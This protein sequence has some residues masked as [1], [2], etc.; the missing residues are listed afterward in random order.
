[1]KNSPNQSSPMRSPENFDKSDGLSPGYDPYLSLMDEVPGGV[2]NFDIEPPLGQSDPA[3]PITCVEIDQEPD[4]VFATPEQSSPLRRRNY[5]IGRNPSRSSSRQTSPSPTQRSPTP[6]SPIKFSE[7]KDLGDT[8]TKISR[9]DFDSFSPIKDAESQNPTGPVEGAPPLPMINIMSQIDT[10]EYPNE[11][12]LVVAGEFHHYSIGSKDSIG[13]EIEVN[14]KELAR[15]RQQAEVFENK[16]SNLK[17]L[18]KTDKKK[19][20]ANKFGSNNDKNSGHHSDIG[21][22]NLEFQS[23]DSKNL[24]SL[25]GL[26]R[27]LAG[28]DADFIIDLGLDGDSNLQGSAGRDLDIMIA[29]PA[30]PGL[31]QG[32]SSQMGSPSFNKGQKDSSRI[33]SDRLLKFDEQIREAA[34]RAEKSQRNLEIRLRDESADSDG[35][36]QNIEVQDFEKDDVLPDQDDDDLNAS[37]SN[38]RK[39]LNMFGARAQYSPGSSESKEDF[40]DIDLQNGNSAEKKYA[41]V[42]KQ[43]NE[44]KTFMQSVSGM[45]S[46]IETNQK[47]LQ[48]IFLEKNPNQVQEDASSGSTL[49][50]LLTTEMNESKVQEFMASAKNKLGV[51]DSGVKK[52]LDYQ[53]LGLDGSENDP[54]T[55]PTKDFVFESPKPDGGSFGDFDSTPPTNLRISNEEQMPVKLYN[56]PMLGFGNKSDRT[57]TDQD[58]KMAF[59][60]FS[61]M[62][63][64]QGLNSSKE[65]LKAQMMQ[66][67]LGEFERSETL[68]Q[69]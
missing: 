53:A 41:S 8:K 23:N 46:K 13:R 52:M 30:S 32:Q 6:E 45:V 3:K 28:E 39:G 22:K 1:V 38:L 21:K 29:P 25:S 19:T 49:E 33:S 51:L 67:I 60:S 54:K 36:D 50:N 40:C 17:G 58:N 5:S 16:I 37:D 43:L 63:K 24:E 9:N 69:S 47:A 34:I 14:E 15:L 42:K 57:G 61:D 64:G 31:S 48:K 55:P 2:K 68:V 11:R 4:N 26:K 44:L 66:E 20:A 56:I 65:T 12:N 7:T 10:D 18:S 27:D 59:E 35:Q 62:S